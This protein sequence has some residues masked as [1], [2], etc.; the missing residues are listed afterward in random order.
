MGMKIL[1]CFLL[2]VFL[3]VSSFIFANE[4]KF[5][6]TAP[7][8]VIVGQPFHLIFSVNEDGKDLH[9]PQMTGFEVIAG[10]AVS[11]SSS[12]SWI[13]GNMTSSKEVCY[14]YTLLPQKEGDYQISSASIVV[15]KKKY[16][17][18]VVNI[19]VL[20]ED[21]TSQVQQGA[22]QSAQ[23]QQSQSIT[24]E[25]LFFRP[26]ISRTKVREQE[27][28]QLTYRLYSRIDISGL[29]STPKFPDYKGFLLQEVDLPQNASQQLENYNGKNY[30]TWDLRKVLLYPQQVGVLVIEPASCD[31]VVRVRS[32]HQRP[33]SFFDDYFDTYQEVVKTIT[34]PKL[35]IEV[36]SLP[37]P[38]PTDFSGVVGKLSMKTNISA[39][40][41]NVNQPI[42]ITLVLQGAG[43]LKLL[44]NPVLKFPQDFETYEPKVVNSF[45][46][47]E[48]GLSGSKTIEYLVIP[49]HGGDFV[50]PS[51][52]ISYFD[53][54]SDS[55]KTLSTEVLNIRVNKGDQLS[56]SAPIVSNFTA[57]E[58][59]EVLSSDIR[60]IKIGEPKLVVKDR[61]IVGTPFFW[62]CYVISFGIVVVLVFV[63]RK[64]ARDNANVALMRNKKANKVARRRLKIAENQLKARNKDVF[65]DEIL[66]ALWGYLSDKLSIP[67]SELNKDNIALRLSQHG[68]DDELVLQ[69]MNLL[70]DC[71]FE[72]YAPI[73]AKE[74]AMENMF[75]ST[76][77]II[78][79]LENTIK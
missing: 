73:E 47:S 54:A 27:V 53:V 6:A 32:S 79:T 56:E 5:K 69:F 17:S 48:M 74:A 23:M 11:T 4:V 70:N 67:V 19:K 45:N 35:N 22:S 62:F 2:Y 44:K 21:K 59:V 60:Y 13:N 38:R 8:Q 1:K 76:V 15:E 52:T 14:T 72:R 28:I 12:A 18:N 25:N 68:L 66:K 31:V 77:K 10:P 26:I 20:P 61:M 55:Y 41:V 57:Q 33:R 49:R 51:T 50:I 65:Y 43:N 71:E 7:S 9:I 64:Q 30:Y 58:R 36:E 42:T 39:A 46:N 16:Y 78:S 29:S 3:L 24:A 34:T 63:F 37:K 40:E 75:D